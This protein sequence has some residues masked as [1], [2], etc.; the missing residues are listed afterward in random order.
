MERTKK[1]FKC[2]RELPLSEFY[3]HP[4]MGDEHLNK[5]KDCTKKDIR[6]NYE[7]K[8]QNPEWFEKERARG[9]EKYIRLGYSHRYPKYP[10]FSNRNTRRKLKCRGFFISRNEEVHHWNYKLGERIIQHS[11]SEHKRLHQHLKFDS[12][13]QKFFGDGV[14]LAT[15]E[16]HLRFAEGVIGRHLQLI[17]F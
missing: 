14:L 1:C 7:R 15:P 11:R 3:R 12:E 5:C 8:S 10:H 16:Q 13:S 9:R 6:F 2:G 17:S 4:K